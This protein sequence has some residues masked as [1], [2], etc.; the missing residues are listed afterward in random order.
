MTGL[1]YKHLSAHLDK[2]ELVKGHVPY[3]TARQFSSI[4]TATSEQLSP[5]DQR[6]EYFS[7]LERK[8]G[9][10]L[11]YMTNVS[12][13]RTQVPILDVQSTLDIAEALNIMHP[14]YEPRTQVSE[15][16]S[17]FQA[18]IMTTDFLFDYLDTA[19]GEV[20]TV[21]VS[22]K[23]NSEVIDLHG[24]DRVIQ[25]IHD[26]FEIERCYWENK[27]GNKF[28][29]ITS[30]YWMFEKNLIDNI[31]TARVHRKLEIPPVLET[32]LTVYFHEIL[33]AKQKV[34]LRLVDVIR[35]IAMKTNL[36]TDH[37]YSVFWY[38]VWTKKI[39]ID[40][41]KPLCSGEYVFSGEDFTWA[42]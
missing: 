9:L 11:G 3:K 37:L 18:A 21:A 29:V 31:S 10:V 1:T 15:E 33:S 40:L 27:Q 26:K 13:V 7:E 28:I 25:R 30:H 41:F 36:P 24:D 2:Q 17:G 34:R 20:V 19:T 8:F 16:N 4:G 32:S 39:K 12:N 6:H 38:F 35:S 23:Y 5:L 42:W 14:R 22:L